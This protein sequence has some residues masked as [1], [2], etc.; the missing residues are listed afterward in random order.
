MTGKQYHS[1]KKVNV[2]GK[3]KKNEQTPLLLMKHI[4]FD[5]IDSTNTWAKTHVDQWATEGVTLI[6]ASEQTAGRGRFKR[7]WESPRDV[8]IYATFCLWLDLQ[9]TDMGYI[10]QLLALAAAQTLEKEGFL[11]TIKWPNDVL[12]RNKKVA[13]ILCETILEKD[14]RG[15]VCGIGLNVNMPFEALSQIDRPATSLLEETKQFFNVATILED[16]QKKFILFLQDFMTKGFAPFFPLLQERSTFKKG[17]IVR[18][19]DNQTFIEAQFDAMHPDGSVALCLPDGTV[20]M[21]HAGE[22]LF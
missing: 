1:K 5:Q 15:V 12:L 14:R 17:D 13:G 19:H 6:T 8:N 4:H 18:F 3:K 20:K 21:Y 16:L 10:P 7:K 22:F 2:Q 9:R 11:P